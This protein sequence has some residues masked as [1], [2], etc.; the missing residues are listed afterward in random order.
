MLRNEPCVCASM[1]LF[2]VLLFRCFLESKTSWDDPRT[3]MYIPRVKPFEY[4][5]QGT[6]LRVPKEGP[7]VSQ[8]SCRTGR[9]W[10]Q[11][12]VAPALVEGKTFTSNAGPPQ[13]ILSQIRFQNQHLGLTSLRI[14]MSQMWS[15]FL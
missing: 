9:M 8:R 3:Y 11:R 14:A 13:T 6:T 1:S 4:D 15:H 10:S 7:D 12:H 5:S 2:V